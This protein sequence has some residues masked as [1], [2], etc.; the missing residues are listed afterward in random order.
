[1]KE[2]YETK[3]YKR[4]HKINEA[5]QKNLSVRIITDEGGKVIGKIITRYT[6]ST[7]GC[8]C[9]VGLALYHTKD[10]EPI[11]LAERNH[12]YGYDMERAN[13][14]Y[15]LIHNKDKL[16]KAYLRVDDVSD[17]FNHWEDVFTNSNY[18]VTQIL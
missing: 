12:G 5:A 17:L 10:D 9:A 15:I 2:F 18:T 4:F 13:I 6:K 3:E 14:E 11:Y 7:L 8:N 1:M 16:T